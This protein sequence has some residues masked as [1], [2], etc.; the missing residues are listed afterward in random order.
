MAARGR[1]KQIRT[2]LGLTQAK[3]A[4]HIGMSLRA[5][6]DNE[7][8]NPR[9]AYV[10]AAEFL[11]LCTAA[12]FDDPSVLPEDMREEYAWLCSQGFFTREPGPSQAMP[13]AA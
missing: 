13:G 10:L 8:G 11:A 4:R 5:Y 12:A 2:G 9:A 1:L 7:H 3:M 6:V